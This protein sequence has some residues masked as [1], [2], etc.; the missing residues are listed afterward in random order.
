M[1]AVHPK[2]WQ[3]DIFSTL[4]IME[5]KLIE[6]TSLSKKALSF[7]ETLCSKAEALIKDCKTDI[8][9]VEIIYPTLRFLWYEL[10]VQA[11]VR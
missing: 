7:S 8:D 11:K 1:A 5:Q 10:Q 2:F 3:F 9:N 6:L 4:F